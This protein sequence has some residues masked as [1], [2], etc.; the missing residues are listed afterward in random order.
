MLSLQVQES[1][2]CKVQ[3]KQIDENQKWREKV[4]F[5]RSRLGRV[6]HF[7]VLYTNRVQFFSKNTKIGT[8]HGT[9]LGRA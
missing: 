1:N 6:A 5:V 7:F 8:V 4:E 2:Y 3:N 9:R